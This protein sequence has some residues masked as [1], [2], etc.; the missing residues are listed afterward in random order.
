MHDQPQIFGVQPLRL[1]FEQLLPPMV[2]DALVDSRE[3]LA[4]TVAPL[5]R[6]MLDAV[7]DDVAERLVDRFDLS[8][9]GGQ[10][11]RDVNGDLPEDV[12]QTLIRG[13][14]RQAIQ[15]LWGSEV[16]LAE[17]VN[18]VLLDKL[19]NDSRL[20][21]DFLAPLVGWLLQYREGD[22][23]TGMLLTMGQDQY[24]GRLSLGSEGRRLVAHLPV[25]LAPSA[26]VTQERLLRDI[27]GHWK[28]ELRTNPAWSSFRK[29]ITVHS[30]G[31]CPMHEREELRVTEDDGQV[32]GCEG[33]YVMDAAAFPTAVGVNP[34]ATIAAVA[35]YKI[36]RIL[37]PDEQKCDDEEKEPPKVDFGEMDPPLCQKD[38]DRWLGEIFE[39]HGHGFVLDPINRLDQPSQSGADVRVDRADIRGRDVPASSM[40]ARARSGSRTQRGRRA[41]RKSR[42]RLGTGSVRR[43]RRCARQICQRGTTRY[44][45]ATGDQ[46]QPN[47][48][49][50]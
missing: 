5:I 1:S 7:L 27:A 38:I 44:W 42:M 31:G 49:D 14:L 2:L 32:V 17:R 13:L 19:R 24:R 33:L 35:E 8:Q 50:Q 26:R 12:K 15:V 28:G 34:S 10:L 22:G 45:R 36:E 47:R 23:H 46:R 16:A 30:Q 18:N 6:P 43:Q 48:D 3:A 4:Q 29:R 21:A 25:P 20:I 40:T 39:R 9:L 41:R 37:C 11:G